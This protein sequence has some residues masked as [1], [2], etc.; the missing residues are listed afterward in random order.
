MAGRP[1]SG[2]A[3][4]AFSPARSCSGFNVPDL[5]LSQSANHRSASAWNSALETTPSSSASAWA[6]IAGPRNI[7]EPNAPGPNAAAA[8]FGSSAAHCS[9]ENVRWI[10]QTFA[11]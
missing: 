5:G 3:K 8:R 9:G 6:K 7:P 4:A 11:T 2:G 1:P 10:V